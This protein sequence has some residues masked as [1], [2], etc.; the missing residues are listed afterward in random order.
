MVI[1]FSTSVRRG[2]LCGWTPQVTV[3]LRVTKTFLPK[4]Q[5]CKEKLCGHFLGLGLMNYVQQ[6][7]STHTTWARIFKRLWS[8]GINSKEWINSAS[9][10]SLAGRYDNPIPPRFLAPIDC[11]KI[12]AL[13]ITEG[14]P[15][16]KWWHRAVKEYC[17]IWLFA[18]YFVTVA[19]GW[20]T[21]I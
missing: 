21:K 17:Y 2:I 7:G 13:C 9:L 3:G 4:T 6:W 16:Q 12:P 20:A 1:L 18:D 10:C 11:L 15:L 5:V 19:C 8:P 14:W